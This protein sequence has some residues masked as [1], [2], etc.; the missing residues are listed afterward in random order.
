MTLLEVCTHQEWTERSSKLARLTVNGRMYDVPV[1]DHWSLAYVLREKVGLTGTKETC[2]EGECGNCTVLIDGKPVLSCLTLAVES[3][4]RQI[5]TIE[6]LAK[7]GKLHPI[8]DA[9]VKCHGVSC[10]H[11]TPSMILCAYALLDSNPNPS[12]EDI[13]RAISGVL[14]RC[15]GYAKIVESIET[16]A[17]TPSN[18]KGDNNE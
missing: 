2:G 16:A 17:Q 10:G 15:T 11:C 13:R 5:T 14:C 1:E 9:F 8:Q 3:E 12:E 7:N 6:G 4:G 18:R